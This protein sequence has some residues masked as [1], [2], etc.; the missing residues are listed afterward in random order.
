MIPAIPRVLRTIGPKYA[1]RGCTD[2]MVQAKVCRGW[3]GLDG[4]GTHVAVSKFAWH[5][6]LYRQVQ[7]LVGQGIH[8][9]RATLAGWVKRAAWW[10]ESL[11]QLL[12]TI[13]ASPRLLCD[14]TPMPVLDPGRHRTRICQF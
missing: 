7:M 2:G 12:K 14:E 11:Y 3:H 9:D 13:Q 6:P 5:L 4:A 8:L 10:L 1:C